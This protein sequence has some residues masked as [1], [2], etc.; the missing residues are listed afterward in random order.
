MFFF[1]IGCA[2]FAF[3]V[4][5]LP[6]LFILGYFKIIT[7][8]F[9]KLGLSPEITFLLLIVILIGSAINIPLGKR[10]F[11]YRKEPSF[12]EFWGKPALKTS[13]VFIN[14]GGAIIPMFL[15]FYFLYQGWKIGCSLSL[16]LIAILLMILVSKSLAKIVPGKG[17]ALPF[18]VPPLFATVFALVLTPNFAPLCAFVSGTLGTLIGADFLNLKKAGRVSS[19]LISI[20]GAGVFD[21]IFLVGIVSA[22]LAGF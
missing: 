17:I 21:G 9:E 13:G 19:G 11:E 5:L 10:K 7:I 18:F 8:G 20:G 4:F 1:P 2:I 14:L 16:L 3:F 22:L 6:I 12:F 15:S